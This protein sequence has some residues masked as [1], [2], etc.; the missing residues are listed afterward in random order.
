MNSR[1]EEFIVEE[2]VTKENYQYDD[3]YNDH[4]NDSYY[5]DENHYHDSHYGDSFSRD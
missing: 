1:L 5:S 3:Q 2:I 4:Y